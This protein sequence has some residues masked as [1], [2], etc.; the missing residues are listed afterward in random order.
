MSAANSLCLACSSSL[1]PSRRLSKD[2]LR[3][4]FITTCCTRP[5]CPSC[6]AS[7]PRLARYNPCLQCLAG[8]NIVTARSAAHKPLNPGLTSHARVNVDGGVHDEDVFALGDDEDDSDDDE[9]HSEQ[10]EQRDGVP[11]TPPPP[12]DSAGD[13]QESD[14]PQIT[15][16]HSA[17]GEEDNPS[18]SPSTSPQPSKYYIKPGDTL[19]GISLK[20]KIDGRLLCRLNNLPQSTLRTTPHLLHTRTV[21]T[22]PPSA[23][24]PLEQTVPPSTDPEYESRRAKERAEKRFQTLTKEVDWRVAKTY[25]ALASDPA[26]AA[27]DVAENWKSSEISD[28]K[29]KA[30]GSLDDEDSNV[31]LEASAIDRYLDDEEWERREREQGRGVSIPRFPLFESSSVN[32]RMEG[33]KPVQAGSKFWS[34]WKWN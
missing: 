18:P 13:Q 23:Q 32:C 4:I 6:L 11:S 30:S 27:D 22:L 28:K 2:P 26:L 8:V 24:V 25:V 20:Y 3:G 31:N 17:S 34:G 29:L 15:N 16:E 14:P 19:L 9:N 1:P 21:L 5:I 7:N 10:H 12:Y 33:K